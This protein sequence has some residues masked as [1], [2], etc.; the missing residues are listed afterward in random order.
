MALWPS[1]ERQTAP[2]SDLLQFSRKNQLLFTPI[3]TRSSWTPLIKIP[4][5]FKMSTL[6]NNNKICYNKVIICLLF[7]LL[8]LFLPCL[9]FKPHYLQKILFSFT[10][11]LHLCPL[12]STLFLKLEHRLQRTG[13]AQTNRN[14][15]FNKLNQS[16]CLGIF[17]IMFNVTIYPYLNSYLFISLKFNE[18][19]LNSDNLLFCGGQDVS[20][21]PVS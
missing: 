2:K 12:L 7:L 1:L 21:G 19:T 10:S 13:T 11:I 9:N 20:R 8:Y 17:S 14:I 3:V 6:F 15:K 16:T 4:N 18:K 5:T